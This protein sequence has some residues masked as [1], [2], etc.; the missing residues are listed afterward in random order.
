MIEQWNLSNIIKVNISILD[1]VLDIV[2][3][4]HISLV[5]ISM[6]KINNLRIC[7]LEGNLVKDPNFKTLESGNEIAIFAIA[8]N[9]ENSV[10]YFDIEAWNDVSKQV[11]KLRLKKGSY[12]QITGDLKQERWESPNGK[13]NSKIKII[14]SSLIKINGNI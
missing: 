6:N 7:V 4:W 11:E 2:L 14:A 13:I 12:A 8:V 1:G 10:S 3:Y 5:E 9:H